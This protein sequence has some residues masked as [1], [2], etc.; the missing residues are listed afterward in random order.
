MVTLK[1]IPADSKAFA[2]E[3]LI[4]SLKSENTQA[5][6][7]AMLIRALEEMG[8][9]RDDP[10]LSSLF[11]KLDDM[12]ESGTLDEDGL[13]YLLGEVEASLVGRALS[14]SLVIPAFDE[15][16]DQ[17]D[18]IFD[19]C[20]D[21]ASGSVASYIPQLARVDPEKFAMA[22]CTIDGQRHSVGDDHDSFCVQSTCKPVNYA[23]AHGLSSADSIHSHVGREPS[24]RSFNELTL[25][26][27][28]LPHNPMINAGAIMASSLIKPE[29]SLADRFDF[30]M[31]KW[32]E[33]GG[34]AEPGFDNT[35]FLS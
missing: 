23:I 27:A 19:A 34:G 29:E 30:V 22:V 13:R 18:T 4:K 11:A 3:H 31:S 12:P 24:G 32:R 6:S 2:A 21:E 35:V 14:G 20:R 16:R 17:L 9:Q 25:N 10:R 5:V 28:G 8:L 7:N 1:S 15:F 26:P 33:L